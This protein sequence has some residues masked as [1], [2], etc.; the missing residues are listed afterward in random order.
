MNRFLIVL[1][2]IMLLVGGIFYW[3][4][5]QSST[6]PDMKHQVLS[7]DLYPLYNGT[8]H[9]GVRTVKDPANYEILTTLGAVGSLFDRG[10]HIPIFNYSGAAVSAQEGTM[11]PYENEVVPQ[12]FD[13]LSG[14]RM[15][16]VHFR[17]QRLV[18]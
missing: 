9:I 17:A 10:N 16:A 8:F 5:K 2:T 15:V 12:Q 6:P 7:E 3:Q 1:I 4:S 14:I 13:A 11:T 18:I